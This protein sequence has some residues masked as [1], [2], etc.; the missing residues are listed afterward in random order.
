MPR[1]PLMPKLVDVIRPE[2]ERFN[3]NDPA[4]ATMTLSDC[5]FA[6]LAVFAFKYPSL[7]QYDNARSDSTISHNLRTLYGIGTLPCDTYMRERLDPIDANELKNCFR[8]LFAIAQRN[9]LLER[10]V[11]HGG[12]YLI[13]LDGTGYFSSKTV[14]CENCCTKNHRDGSVTFYHQVLQGALVHPDMKQVIPLAPEMIF[15]QDGASKNDA[16]NKASSR[17]VKQFREDH[18]VL[19]VTILADALHSTEPMVTRLRTHNMNF[20][21][22][23]K[24]DSHK[25]LFE[26]VEKSNTIEIEDEDHEGVIRRYRFLNDAPLNGANDDVRVNYLEY[27]E[28]PPK[29]KKRHFSWVTDF[30]LTPGNV[31]D[32]MRGGR[33]RWKIENETF[34]TLKT[35]GY[36]F[37]HNFGHG[38]RNLSHVFAHLILLAFLMDQL[39]ELNCNF[40]QQALKVRKRKLYFWNAVR[41]KITELAIP[42]WEVLYALLSKTA[43]VESQVIFD[44]S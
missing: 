32:I 12:K 39:V 43:R 41:S 15:K 10:Y 18:P 3:K 42:T 28:I 4:R 14:H 31:Y 6:G 23:V 40:F 19:D 27:W 24:P 20:I 22:N 25:Y 8:K 21:L 17:W 7:L 44:S 2:F 30:E 16:E 13:S 5:L 1:Q 34:N 38:K 9:K 36:E 26:W 37:E 33:A 35:Q 29:G 11:Y